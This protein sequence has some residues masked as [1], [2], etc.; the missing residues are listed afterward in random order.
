MFEHNSY[1]PKCLES[2]VAMAQL[3][4]ETEVKE[5]ASTPEYEAIKKQHPS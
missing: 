5:L 3:I 2:L 4:T 1:N